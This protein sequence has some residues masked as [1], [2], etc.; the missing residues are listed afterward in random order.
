MALVATFG[1]GLR[2]PWPITHG[3][4]IAI[5]TLDSWNQEA[6]QKFCTVS[7]IGIHTTTGRNPVNI[8]FKIFSFLWI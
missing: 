6:Q 1:G 7:G 5:M 4:M 2:D 3:M 8:I